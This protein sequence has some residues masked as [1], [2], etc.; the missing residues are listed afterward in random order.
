MTHSVFPMY[1]SRTFNAMFTNSLNLEK[2]LW[3]SLRDYLVTQG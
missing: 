2:L 3:Y 1:D